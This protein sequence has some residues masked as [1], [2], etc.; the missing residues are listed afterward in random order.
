MAV[1]LPSTTAVAMG[2]TIG[3]ATDGNK[4]AA[5]QVNAASGGRILYPGSGA[6]VTSA[7]LAAANYELLVLQFDGEQFSGRSGDTQRRRLYWG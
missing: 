5:V 1:T 7:S 6:T 2:W 4:A 3:I